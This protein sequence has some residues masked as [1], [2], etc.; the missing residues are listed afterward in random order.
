MTEAPASPPELASG[1]VLLTL[2]A[3][4]HALSVSERTI[5]RLISD[6]RL[7]AVRVGRAVRVRAVDVTAYADSLL[8]SATQGAPVA[9]EPRPAPPAR[10]QGGSG[11]PTAP[12][13]Q[14][15]ASMQLSALLGMETKTPTKARGRT[16]LKPPRRQVEAGHIR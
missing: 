3:A 11:T 14:P 5:R 12:N 6:G 15:T 9:N 7:P 8:P 4:G 13:G 10:R 1:R 2:A 16:S